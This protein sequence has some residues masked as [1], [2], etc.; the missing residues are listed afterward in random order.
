MRK[1]IAAILSLTLLVSTPV[2]AAEQ[3]TESQLSNDIEV[4]PETAPSNFIID[5]DFSSDVDDAFA[6]STAV[7][8]NDIGL[9]NIKG[10]ALCI[11]SAR[12]GWA[13]SGLLGQHK[14]WEIPICV[15]NKNGLSIGSKYHLG[16][17]TNYPHKENQH[18]NVVSFYRMLLASS[19]DKTNIVTLGQ[20]TNLK[21]LL[22][23]GPDAH[24][25]LTGIEL[26]SQKVDTLYI[27][28][29]KYTGKPENNLWYSGEDY[30]TNKWYG[31]TGVTDAA[32][33]VAKQWP[34]RIVWIPAE[35]GGFYKVG[36]SLIEMDRGKY[37]ILANALRDYGTPEGC[38]A[39]DPATIYVA[40]YDSAGLLEE[41]GL[42]LEKGTM[43]IYSGGSSE[44]NTLE[45]QSTHERI[46]KLF[47]DSYYKQEID[48]ILK[49]E[50]N[51]RHS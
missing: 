29:T 11:G 26:I 12:A 4:T 22:E 6:I 40:A 23:S 10:V 31:T 2:Y 45:T 42:T 38:M 48:Q 27:C 28:G 46:Q 18:T 17:S 41:K 25:D 50:Y 20:L 32:I 51:K 14:H 9:I 34:S 36:S 21:E 8:F 37:D 16:M 13:M 44:F 1:V 19:P 7:Y 5:T 39:F 33:M 49:Y 30:G 43:H 35:V 47:P 15:D 24:S 3:R